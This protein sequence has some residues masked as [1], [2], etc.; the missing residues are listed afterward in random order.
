MR[1]TD[2]VGFIRK[3]PHH[4]VASFRA[5]L[6]EAADADVLLH[7]ID[8]AAPTWEEQVEVVELAIA[9]QLGKGETGNEKREAKT[10]HVFN[11]ADLLPE[12]QTF[13]AQVHTRFPDA[14][15]AS[16][17]P[18]SRSTFPAGVDP[19]RDALRRV[20]QSLR[21]LAQ[22]RVPLADGKLLAVL[23]RDAE[24]VEQVQEDGVMKVTVRVEAKLLGKLR[25]D[26]VEV[27]VG[28]PG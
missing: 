20:V 10:I 26:G 12:P 23:H 8:A 3:L 6:E 4:L 24:V 9:E 7:V 15:L 14:V 28:N 25:R 19:L 5:T 16:T 2:T 18:A 21:P 1:V 11:K 17:F 13:L 27:V 22:V